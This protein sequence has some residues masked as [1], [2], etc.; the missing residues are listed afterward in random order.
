MALTDPAT[1]GN[2]IGERMFQEFSKPHFMDL[3]QGIKDITG[4]KIASYNP[5][6]ILYLGILAYYEAST[7]NQTPSE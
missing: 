6:G 2:L 5:L 7:L 4:T 3:L 1:A